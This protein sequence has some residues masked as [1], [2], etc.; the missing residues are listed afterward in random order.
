MSQFKPLKGG[1]IGQYIREEL[2]GLFKGILA[3]DSIAHMPSAL[4]PI[5]FPTLSHGVQEQ[6]PSPELKTVVVKT[7]RGSDSTQAPPRAMP[8]S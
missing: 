1:S 5:E 2:K 3:D 8:K 4:K 7:A 6:A